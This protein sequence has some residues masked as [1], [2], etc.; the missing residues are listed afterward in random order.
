MTAF[1]LTSNSSRIPGGIGGCTEP[2]GPVEVAGIVWTAVD[3][4]ADGASIGLALA[5]ESIEV[6]AC[7]G[8][9]VRLCPDC[10]PQPTCE[11]CPHT[12]PDPRCSCRPDP[13]CV[14]GGAL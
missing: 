1:S 2:P 6:P 3:A 11:A 13:L 5:L 7:T 8:C 10:F 12:T 9:E 14:C 4:S